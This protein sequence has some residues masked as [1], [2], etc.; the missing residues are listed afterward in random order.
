MNQEIL[1]PVKAT[2]TTVA[3]TCNRQSQPRRCRWRYVTGSAGGYLQ[4]Q[5]CGVRDTAMDAPVTLRT[6]EAMHG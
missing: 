2:P 4:C 5:A 6:A 1:K 3:F